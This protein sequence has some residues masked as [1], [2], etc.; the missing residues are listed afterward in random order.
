M[1]YKIIIFM[2]SFHNKGN[3]HSAK[4]FHP[5]ISINILNKT[6]LINLLKRN[7]FRIN[8]SADRINFNFDAVVMQ[9]NHLPQ[10]GS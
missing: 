10:A 2:T 4:H 3:N 1:D 6:L 8:I 5:S 9:K 7:I